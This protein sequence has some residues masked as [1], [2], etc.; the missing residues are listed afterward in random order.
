ML[1]LT[2]I[3]RAQN[4][5]DA[6]RYANVEYYGDARFN[7]MGGSFGALGANMSSLSINP[8]GI[9]VYKS[10][11]FSFTPSFIYNNTE[12]EIDGFTNVDGRLSFN[13]NNVG[14]VGHFDT[15]GDWKNVN[16]A[17]GYNR[18]SNYNTRITIKSVTD[19]SFLTTYTD[20]LNAGGG[21]FEEE[22]FDNFP[23]SSSLAYETFLVNPLATNPLQ[24]DHVFANSENI[25]QLTSYR[26]R[27]GSGEAYFAFGGN[28]SDKLYLGALVGVPTVRYVFDRD[29][30]E[31]SEESDTLTEFKS[32]SVHDFVRTTG[33]GINLKLGLIYKV[34]D[35]FRLG[36]SFHTPTLYSLSD[37]WE[38]TITS[39]NKNGEILT[40]ES[41]FG[42]FD[43]F[44]TTPYRFIS[45]A[46]FIL[47][48]YGVINGDYEIVD[49]S[50]SRLSDDDS[51]GVADFSLENQSIR[52]NF[53]IAQNIRI[54]T[55]WRLDPFRLRAGYRYQGNPIRE[56]FSADNS[57]SIYSVGAGIK[58]DEYYFDVSYSLKTYQAE[59]AIVAEQGDFALVDLQDHLISF[60]LGFRF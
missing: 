13:F 23:F 38:T 12:N 39:E 32:F 41:P 55:E 42:N 29:Y 20:E 51:F 1:S 16:L 19:E 18:T 40:D 47:G 8:G 28:Y 14:L 2:L 26:T 58:Q 37:Q 22:I 9:A 10:S 50:T 46:S 49:Y 7:A 27:G 3:A 59:S 30:T 6:L 43:Y 25:T 57:S 24:Y 35:W 36:A 5:F 56:E 11:D 31:I 54:G 34:Q 52:D 4:E 33:S 21:I 44:V 45:S 53:Q 17:I 60:T 15:D 48:K